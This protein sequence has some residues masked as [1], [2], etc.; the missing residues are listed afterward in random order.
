MS[1]DKHK[2][3]TYH[4]WQTTCR[5]VGIDGFRLWNMSIYHLDLVRGT[6]SSTGHMKEPLYLIFRVGWGP[7]YWHFFL[8]CAVTCVTN[9]DILVGQQT[10]YLLG[11]WLSNWTEEAWI[12]PRWSSKDGWKNELMLPWCI[13][14]VPSSWICVWLHYNHGL[15]AFQCHLVGRIFRL[16][17]RIGIGVKKSNS[18]TFVDLTP[19][20]YGSTLGDLLVVILT[21]SRDCQWLDFHPCGSLLG[22]GH[23]FLIDVVATS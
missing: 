5:C 14:H 22:S 20:R 12:W 3:S 6:K 9:Y 1:F 16:G 4:D 19:K 2:G 10:L 8:K 7:T 17:W 15:F 18:S 13:G 11:F 21:M 23:H